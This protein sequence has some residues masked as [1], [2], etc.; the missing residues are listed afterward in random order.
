MN[1]I[2]IFTYLTILAFFIR[3]SRNIFYNIFLWQLKEYRIDRLFA[4]L[5]TSQ[6]KKF[7]LGPIT[8]V[9]WILFL[10]I[11]TGYDIYFYYI[12]W[13]IWIIEAVLGIRE[14]VLYRWRL[15]KFTIKVIFILFTV[16][17]IIS[18]FI[19]KDFTDIIFEILIRGVYVDRFINLAILIIIGLLSFPV[20]IYKKLIIWKAQKKIS[21]FNNLKVIGI[22]G[23]YGKTST[24][25]FLATILGEKFTVA[26]TPEFTNTDIGIAKF[27]LKELQ[28]AH[29][30]FVV[31]MGAYKKGEIKVI[32]NMVKPQ[33]GV[34]TGINEQHL[35]LFGSI[36]NTKRAKFELIESLTKG[37]NAIFNGNNNHCVEM[38]EW[39]KAL[40]IK[41]TTFKT[42]TDVK[43]INVFWDHIE[44]CLLDK[45]KSYQFKV[46]LLGIQSL[47]NLLPA[48]YA[49]R[50]LG[51]NLGEIQKGASK[52]I[53]PPKTMQF[54]E[55]KKGTTLIDDTF[56]A[57]PDGVIAAIKYIRIFKGKKILVLTPLIELGHE[58]EKIHKFLG[59][60][61]VQVCDL[62]LLTNLNY[63]NS[64]IEGAK[65]SSGE[66]KV[67]IV[68]AL[69][70]A[71][72]LRENMGKDGVVVFEG[73]EA[74]RILQALVKLD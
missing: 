1:L 42:V 60:R 71:K 16:F 53:S 57:N 64:F 15:P 54:I 33:I 43:N 32:C 9:K 4:Y 10:G 48:I 39:T 73:K 34:I 27:I 21:S 24:K 22:T 67:R 44:F 38:A 25:D 5:K 3:T 23:S 74:G 47:E 65:K 13:L 19:L 8:L 58:A 7:M 51:L 56:N 28:P 69:V 62:V 29:E 14:L 46:D 50:C 70:G 45:N 55:N 49:A 37:G 20:F 18:Y 63:H 17:F 11:L 36:E 68:N 52:I 35:E 12:F 26:K 2:A 40:K 66:D 59:E 6:G 72:L 31:E 30:V 41:A 61:I